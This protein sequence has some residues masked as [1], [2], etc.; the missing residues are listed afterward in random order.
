M[1]EFVG[2]ES[3]APQYEPL[4]AI[5]GVTE[6]P[7]KVKDPS[8]T[9]VVKGAV[10]SEW[11]LSSLAR[12][13]GRADRQSAYPIRF[14]LTPV[15]NDMLDKMQL[16]EPE[17]EH[18]LSGNS[19]EAF[20][21][22]IKDVQEDRD[23][24]R[25]LADAGMTGTG[26]RLATAILDP[27]MLPLLLTSGGAAAGAKVSRLGA[28]TKGALAAGGISAG[29]EYLLAKGN[30]QRDWEDVLLAGIGGGVLGA[31]VGAITA[32]KAAR[33][34]GTLDELDA[35]AA[36]IDDV[37]PELPMLTDMTKPAGL[38]AAPDKSKLPV[39][40]DARYALEQM[41]SGRIS[42]ETPSGARALL[43]YKGA[44]NAR[45]V[46]EEANA[47]DDFTRKLA[48][49]A[50]LT[51]LQEQIAKMTGMPSALDD[52][53][54]MSRMQRE[55]EDSIQAAAD[56]GPRSIL[57][58]HL[59]DAVQDA[60]RI[61]EQIKVNAKVK[62]AGSGKGLVLSR[63]AKAEEGKR[64]AAAMEE[65]NAK[66]T[67]YT[68]RLAS[69]A[70]AKRDTGYLAQLRE[71]QLPEG[72]RKRFDELKQ[73]GVDMRKVEL[74]GRLEAE[75]KATKLTREIE[76]LE[77]RLDAYLKP[78]A[79]AAPRGQAIVRERIIARPDGAV[80]PDKTAKD[81]AKET[82]LK[83]EPAPEAP[84]PILPSQDDAA[85]HN[86]YRE[87]SVPNLLRKVFDWADQAPR[88]VFGGPIASVGARLSRS[89]FKTIRGLNAMLNAFSQGASGR[90]SA[91]QFFDVFH[92]RSI[93]TLAKAQ[94]AQNEFMARR[95]YNLVTSMSENATRELGEFSNQVVLAIKGIAPTGPDADLIKQAADSM[96]RAYQ[97]GLELRTRTGVRGF[98]H[99]EKDGTYWSFLPQGDKIRDAARRYNPQHVED[100]LTE[101]YLRGARLSRMKDQVKAKE[102]A[103]LIAK[104]QIERANR[105]KLSLRGEA[106]VLTDKNQKFIKTQLEELGMS[107]NA[108]DD[109]MDAM[110]AAE[111]KLVMSSRAKASFGADATV[112]IDGLRVVDLIDTNMDVAMNYG[113][114]AAADAALAKVGFKS[115]ADL[116]RLFEDVKVRTDNTIEKM[117]AEGK[118]TSK[119]EA[120]M[121]RS[122]Q[123]E[124]GFLDDTVR[125]F[126]GRSLDAD[127]TGK[128]PAWVQ[129]SRILRGLGSTVNL[130]WNGLAS[131]PEAGNVIGRQGLG[132]FLRNLPKFKMRP[133]NFAE[134]DPILEEWS[135]VTGA[136]GHLEGWFYGSR[137]STDV[138]SEMAD[139]ITNTEKFIRSVGEKQQLLSGF[140][141]IQHGWE[142]MNLRSMIHN[143][144][145]AAQ[146]GKASGRMYS[147]FGMTG[148]SPDELD[149][150][151]K[152]LKTNRRT[153][154]RDGI[155]YNVPDLDKMDVLMRDKLGASMT[156]QLHSAVQRQM[157]GETP[158]ILNREFG[159]AA[160][161]FMSFTIASI[162]KQL[163]KGARTDVVGLVRDTM[164]QA[165]LAY[166]TYMGLTWA[167]SKQS[168]DPEKYV[169]DALKPDNMVYGVVSRTGTLGGLGFAMDGLATFGM[170]PDFMR[171]SPGEAGAQ[172]LA[173][174]PA[175]LS[176]VIR[177]TSIPGE[178][179]GHANDSMDGSLDDEKL[180]STNRKL[181]RTLPI[182][183]T[184][185]VGFSYAAL[186][187]AMEE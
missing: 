100:V 40:Y 126:Y 60:A 77:K 103:S 20:E 82:P 105:T 180:A 37:R 141:H 10:E 93:G 104:A 42:A 167:K 30:T 136:Y 151:M 109:W 5:R 120:A 78:E 102:V 63:A 150:V 165:G 175:G 137:K 17:R 66:I 114:E 23:R 34:S 80:Y 54:V 29:T 84:K 47:L 127:A 70:K 91:A 183:N 129:G 142:E 14:E 56:I 19:R 52:M 123:E 135:A 97:E 22:R 144:D 55:I 31:G 172:T 106:S 112:E 76:E 162:E 43:E 147:Q 130:S 124:L 149:D 95:G 57:K 58:G 15:D 187:E 115:R 86:T 138:L 108:I 177:A 65:A 128:L 62:P 181:L 176:T 85:L 71:G 184:A 170:V 143:L 64:L 16:T 139:G 53:Q 160:F 122:L 145:K 81:F 2:W 101:A 107:G 168:K 116:T 156:T 73:E 45:S 178:Y 3:G 7:A 174:T 173:K 46:V 154:E 1:A 164:W 159:R 113:R 59:D 72:M 185:A 110:R 83:G 13:E 99:V 179:L 166:M 75:Y 41:T 51:K 157:I 38:L 9:D 33:A 118:L 92:R 94:A 79:P 50:E 152:F 133:R 132:T 68:E 11:V 161:Q 12:M 8:F 21:H 61:S 158:A 26:V 134:N 148:M 98:E 146:T 48:A 90:H 25:M 131:I 125:Q 89:D 4:Q 69:L 39:L 140:K 121:R 117:F 44:L 49:E 182:I 96:R 88:A 119:E 32:G 111:D 153:V 36:H 27:T 35:A 163:V 28:A 18:I 169:E 186:S 24:E 155:S 171:A 87:S 67:R 6:K 74:N